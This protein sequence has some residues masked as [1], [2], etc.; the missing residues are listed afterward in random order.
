MGMGGGNQNVFSRNAGL[1]RQL[2]PDLL[3]QKRIRMGQILGKQ[4]HR[5]I[6]FGHS[7]AGDVQI[8]QNILRHAV[9]GV[10]VATHGNLL[11]QI[12]HDLFPGIAYLQTL[13]LGSLRLFS[14]A[15]IAAGAH[16]Q[17]QRS[18]HQ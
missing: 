13:R 15:G 3:D 17:K 6:P 2:F 1:R 4:Q 11:A 14:A 12:G 16:R 9:I 10:A 7:N 8:V 5:L 18:D